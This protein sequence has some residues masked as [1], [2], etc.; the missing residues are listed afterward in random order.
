MEVGV[1]VGVG[2]GVKVGVGVGV[3]VGVEVGVIAM[4]VEWQK[5]RTVIKVKSRWWRSETARGGPRVRALS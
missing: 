2:V 1:E 5:I 3:G 4:T